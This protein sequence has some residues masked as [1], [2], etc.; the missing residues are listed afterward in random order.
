MTNYMHQV[1]EQ[2]YTT[3]LNT[4]LPQPHQIPPQSTKLLPAQQ[5]NQNS[6]KAI[7]LPQLLLK[8][9]DIAKEELSIRVCR[10]IMAEL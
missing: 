5:T 3:P 10:S 6:K 7:D 9:V 4:L 8:P 1:E 2:K